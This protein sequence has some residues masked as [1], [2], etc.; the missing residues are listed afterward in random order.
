MTLRVQGWGDQLLADLALGSC[1]EAHG[2]NWECWG[3][4][5]VQEKNRML[6]CLPAWGLDKGLPGMKVEQKLRSKGTLAKE[7]CLPS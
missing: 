1:S 6:E 7:L 2:S 5:G 3:G 4:L